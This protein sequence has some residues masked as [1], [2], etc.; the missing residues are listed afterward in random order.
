MPDRTG[1]PSDCPRQA[2]TSFWA[3]SRMLRI[4]HFTCA[5][6]WKPS[7]KIS[8]MSARRLFDARSHRGAIRLP[9]SGIN[10]FLDWIPADGKLLAKFSLGPQTLGP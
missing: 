2:S 6:A 3:R 8:P 4:D 9:M 5:A 1:A 10:L 7:Y